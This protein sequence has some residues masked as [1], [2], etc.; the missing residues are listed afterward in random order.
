M[1]GIIEG[2]ILYANDPKLLPVEDALGIGR[3]DVKE[4]KV[5]A[6]APLLHRLLQIVPADQVKDPY[7]LD[8]KQWISGELMQ[9]SNSSFI[10]ARSNRLQ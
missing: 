5:H 9:D 4:G 7:K 6:A 1:S 3:A 10:R 8:M 2:C